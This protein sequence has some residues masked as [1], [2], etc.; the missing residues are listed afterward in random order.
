MPRNQ[1]GGCTRQIR[2]AVIVARHYCSR[3]EGEVLGGAFGLNDA[4][5]CCFGL[6]GR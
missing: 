3:L 2:H 5:G 4:R 6:N 1:L